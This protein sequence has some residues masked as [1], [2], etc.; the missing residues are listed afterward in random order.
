MV[1]SKKLIANGEAS[2]FV[3]ANTCTSIT[4]HLAH[5][6]FF[7][8]LIQV[9]HDNITDPVIQQ[10]GMKMFAMLLRSGTTYHCLAKLHNINKSK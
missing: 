6:I 4:L 5:V 3:K 2:F 9:I 8:E 1:L 10:A 7:R